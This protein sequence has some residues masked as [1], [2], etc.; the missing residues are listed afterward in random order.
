MQEESFEIEEELEDIERL[1]ELSNKA[2]A[3]DEL[4]PDSEKEKNSHLNDLRKDPN[5]KEFFDGE[6]PNTS[7]LPELNKALVESR[8]E[9]IKELFEAQNNANNDSFTNSLR[10]RSDSSSYESNN[11]F[12]KEDYHNY[13]D[14]K[15]DNSLLDSVIEFF[16]DI[17]F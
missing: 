3:L 15:L 12:K 13:S 10:V 17:F 8:K 16:K 4:L 5:V 7:D 14:Y 9:K 6:I 11:T 2:M 1:I